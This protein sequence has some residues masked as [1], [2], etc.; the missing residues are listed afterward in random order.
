V[1]NHDFG[2]F[3]FLVRLDVIA[4][5]RKKYAPAL[6]DQQQSRAPG[7]A[8]KISNVRKMADQQ[9]IKAG[10]R[11]MVPKF[12]LA[13]AEVHCGECSKKAATSGEP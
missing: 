2:A 12:L 7:K 8:A 3:Y 10:G 6:F 5:V 9:P 13:G 4:N 11:K 1:C